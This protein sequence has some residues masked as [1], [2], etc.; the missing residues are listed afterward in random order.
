[1]ASPKKY[2]AKLARVQARLLWLQVQGT[3]GFNRSH[4]DW[5][6]AANRELF[7][8]AEVTLGLGGGASYKAFEKPSEIISF[9]ISFEALC[10][11]KLALSQAKNESFRQKEEL[12]QAAEGFGPEFVKMAT[13]AL[14]CPESE[15]PAADD[16]ELEGIPALPDEPQDEKLH[17]VEETK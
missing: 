3:K 8:F 1:M 7:P 5:L 6:N 14:R 11:I 2:Q 10:G 15:N 16:K 4:E 12:R 17:L 9:K 13:T